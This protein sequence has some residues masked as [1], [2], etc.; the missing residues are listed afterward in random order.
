MRINSLAAR[1][2][3]GFFCHSSICLHILSFRFFDLALTI[4]F[5]NTNLFIN[6]LRRL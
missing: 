2:K 3:S 1:R 5:L 6:V 4:M